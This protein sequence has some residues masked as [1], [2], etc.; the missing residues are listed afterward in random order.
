VDPKVLKGM[1]VSDLG[2]KKEGELDMPRLS[3]SK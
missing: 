3:S 1:L 2:N